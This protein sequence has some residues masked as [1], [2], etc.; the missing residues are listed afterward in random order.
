MNYLG[1]F[2]DMKYFL[3]I[4][5]QYK[6]IGGGHT[7]YFRLAKWFSQ[8]GYAPVLLLPKGTEINY[9]IS[10][11]F[12]KVGV[13]IIYFWTV[14]N[15]IHFSDKNLIDLMKKEDNEIIS[16][17]FSKNYLAV[18]YEILVGSKCYSR[19][20]LY[21]IYYEDGI[22][23]DNILFKKILKYLFMPMIK[24]KCVVA[25]DAE[26]RDI[27]TN[28]LGI[29]KKSI[30]ILNLAHDVPELKRN[31][32]SR[33]P[34]I[35]LTVARFDFPFKGYILGLIDDFEKICDN[36]SD[37]EL[38]IIGGGD[39]EKQ[40]NERISHIN[41]NYK[42]R[43][44]LIGNVAPS[45]L[46]RYYSRASVYVGMGTTILEAADEG[47]I[48]IVAYGF[49]TGNLSC[50]FFNEIQSLGMPLNGK[51][52]RYLVEDKQKYTFYQ[53]IEEV[54]QYDK[55]TYMDKSIKS[56]NLSKNNY[57]LNSLQYFL[58][59]KNQKMITVDVFRLFIY[60]LLCYKILKKDIQ[61]Y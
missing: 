43:I 6:E 61:K 5:H 10:D 49:Q 52:S 13:T 42:N 22:S 27:S 14:G 28:Y 30:Q 24:E 3:S 23:K 36:H 47:V 34:F 26:D 7:Y 29:D 54:I 57:S 58:N 11:S 35:I 55:Q 18:L 15:N 53:L 4:D 38:W 12:Q 33:K 25:M 45:E 50:G 16:I 9:K 8:N 1:Y 17:S 40:V 41:K 39:G 59:F 31:E 37:A 19:L 60:K 21:I 56:Y 44:K 46:N 51:F 48:P 32:Y 20:F 2:K